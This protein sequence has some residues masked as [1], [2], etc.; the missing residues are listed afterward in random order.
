[1]PAP[2]ANVCSNEL[3]APDRRLTR[4]E[5]ANAVEDVFGIDAGALR[6]L[7]PPSSSIGDVPDIL[8]GRL[9]DTS[10]RF[11]K[12]YRE[13]VETLAAQ[14]ASRLAPSCAASQTPASTG[15]EGVRSCVLERLMAPGARLWRARW[16]AEERAGLSSALVAASVTEPEAGFRVGVAHLLA[17][18]QFYSLKNE[19]PEGARDAETA[20]R[21]E[22]RRLATRL[23]LSLWSSVPD[24][25]LL[26]RVERGFASDREFEAEVGRMLAEPRFARFSE[27][28][29][30]QWLRLDRRP[31][32]RP[33]LESR[34]LIE[35]RPR[36]GRVHRDVAAFLGRQL[37][38]ER[39]LAELLTASDPELNPTAAASGRAGLLTSQA[40]LSAISTP[41]RGGGDENWLGRGLLIQSAFLCRSFPLAAVYPSS[42]W[43]KHALLDP[44][45]TAAS[46]RPG[47][48]A[49]LAIRTHDKPCRECHAQLDTL[50]AAL[51]AY[52]GYGAAN[53]SGAVESV[54]VWGS[55]IANAS[56]LARWVSNSGRFETC[57][58]QKLSSYVLG[59]AVLP[60]QRPA[61]RCLVQR[62]TATSTGQPL[63]LAGILRRSLM[64]PEFRAPGEQ[65]IRDKPNPSPNSNEYTEVLAPVTVAASECQHFDAGAFLVGNCG[66]GTCHGAGAKNAAFA[67]Q[68]SET[69]ARILRSG[70]PSPGGYC[71][72]FSSYLDG[73]QPEN[74]LVI[75][76]LIGGERSCG[77]A[78]P[79]T[80]GPRTL[81]PV[82]HA[83]FIAW[84]M[85]QAREQ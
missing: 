28:F 13:A 5:L 71:G 63:T 24:E 34:E 21:F 17:S 26:D 39:P 29:S 58:A 40:L 64:S 30:R 76:K 23:A 54:D 11:L 32:F 7:P 31:L 33:S 65:V 80:G 49:L 37:A 85:E 69:A 35:D 48:R 4:F 15:A 9:L 1:L 52:D 50:G 74:S 6:A 78:M 56:E 42:L 18:P 73:A 20:R 59:R 70:K 45:L 68:D 19:A 38:A 16:N 3:G 79:I 12:P 72:Q 75:R 46:P 47:E 61:D 43:E 81:A 60:A 82:E 83:C 66:T 84:A 41:I 14:A 8:V 25:A 36:L 67:V 10:P 55:S 51:S 57:V 44:R 22:A 2:E 53:A 62:L 77:A 27:E